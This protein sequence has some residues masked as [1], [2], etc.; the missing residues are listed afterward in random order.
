V[1]HTLANS[2]PKIFICPSHPVVIEL[3]RHPTLFEPVQVIVEE[4]CKLRVL[5][6]RPDMMCVDA[7]LYL[8]GHKPLGRN[9][10]KKIRRILSG[11]S[12]N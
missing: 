2:F 9:K 8:E 7:I 3:L 4:G 6:K 12:G 5:L 1:S 11:F 10:Q